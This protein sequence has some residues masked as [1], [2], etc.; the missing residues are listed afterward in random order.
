MNND[1]IIILD[2]KTQPVIIIKNKENVEC[3][4]IIKTLSYVYLDIKSTIKHYNNN[5]INEELLKEGLIEFIK[6]IK[7]YNINKI[8]SMNIIFELELITH[9]LLKFDLDTNIL[10]KL[11]KVNIKDLYNEKFQKDELKI[12]FYYSEN[13]LERVY[14]CIFENYYKDDPYHHSYDDIIM[15][16]KI[17]KKFT[18]ECIIYKKKP[19]FIH[20]ID[21]NDL[22]VYINKKHNFTNP[23]SI[24][25]FDL[26]KQYYN[27]WLP[28]YSEYQKYLNFYKDYLYFNELNQLCN[29]GLPKELYNQIIIICNNCINSWPRLILDHEL[30]IKGEEIIEDL[31]KSRDNVT[32][33]AEILTKFDLKKN[34]DNIVKN[35]QII[36]IHPEIIS[37]YNGNECIIFGI[38]IDYLLRYNISK[39]KNIEFYD[40][41]AEGMKD[42]ICYESYLNIKENK[43]KFPEDIFKTSLLHSLSFKRN[44]TKYIDD[45]KFYKDIEIYNKHL[46]LFYD[47]FKNNKDIYLNPKLDSD[48]IVGDA[49][50]II[51]DFLIDIKCYGYIDSL[52]S[53]KNINQLI[54]YK[55]LTLKKY[56][57]LTKIGFYDF[58]RGEIIY[59]DINDNNII[60]LENEWKK[61]YEWN[62]IIYSNNHKI[63]LHDI[64]DEDE[65]KKF[66]EENIKNED[67]NVKILLEILNNKNRD[68]LFIKKEFKNYEICEKKFRYRNKI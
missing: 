10:E 65:I 47:Y 22:H 35:K 31:F 56:H 30:I 66:I 59:W 38:F 2:I 27:Y 41:R 55:I 39:R 17:C 62:N 5:D 54:I 3:K 45:N 1:R 51:D 4:N 48:K 53:E 6:T 29:N 64:K 34:I 63:D 42:N 60:E 52:L 50:I 43:D 20:D 32:N 9:Y 25:G 24:R 13:I 58:F 14:E 7:E 40:Q 8:I 49:D 23:Q 26:L 57:K 15:K 12:N 11:T 36:K 46:N 37:N 21:P 44:I 18:Q 68:I 16:F 19:T 33:Y 67:N 61:I 28:F